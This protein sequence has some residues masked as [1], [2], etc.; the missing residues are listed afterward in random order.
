MCAKKTA[1]TAPISV[2]PYP[3]P[4][5][6]HVSIIFLSCLLCFLM[7][8]LFSHGCLSSP[9]VPALSH[10]CPPSAVSSILSFSSLISFCC[11]SPVF[12]H[13]CPPSIISFLLF[14]HVSIFPRL[15]FFSCRH[16]P[17]AL[18]SI[19]LSLFSPI[20]PRVIAQRTEYFGSA[21]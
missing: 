8:P 15:L 6:F 21:T 19:F 17:L 20:V 16:P 2:L 13:P 10:L 12:S 9:V 18:S 3:L 14:S 5:F 4:Q 7:S 11:H 1:A